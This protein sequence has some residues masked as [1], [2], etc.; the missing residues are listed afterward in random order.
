MEDCISGHYFGPA[1]RTHYLLH[2]IFKGEGVFEVGGVR[3]H[4]RSLPIIKPTRS[5]LGHTAGL[6]LT[7]RWPNPSLCKQG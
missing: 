5:T 4:L 3:H 7:A 6:V 2:Y 1:V